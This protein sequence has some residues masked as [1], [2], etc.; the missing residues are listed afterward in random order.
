MRRVFL[1][2][3]VALAFPAAL[4]SMLPVALVVAWREVVGQLSAAIVEIWRPEPPPRNRRRSLYVAGEDSRVV[5]F[6]PGRAS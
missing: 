5:T 6:G 3:V 4:V 2:V 1:T